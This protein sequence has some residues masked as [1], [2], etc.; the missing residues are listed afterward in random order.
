[1]MVM[2]MRRMIRMI[3]KRVM[4]DSLKLMVMEKKKKAVKDFGIVSLML[5]VNVIGTERVILKANKML[6]I[7][8]KKKMNE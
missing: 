6:E 3:E 8:K 4:I 2:K 7:L 1:M 5:F